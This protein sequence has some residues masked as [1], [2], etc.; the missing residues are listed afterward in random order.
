MTM[1]SPRI[2]LFAMASTLVALGLAFVGAGGVGAYFSNPARSA[3]AIL[4]IVLWLAALFSDANLSPGEREDRSDRWVLVAFGVIGLLNAFLPAYTD[5]LDVWTFGGETIRWIGVALFAAG[6][7]LRLWPVF[8]LGNRFSGLV[9]IQPGHRLVTSGIYSVIRNPSYL[10]LLVN[11]LGWALVFR[12][13]AGLMLTA[14]TLVPLVARIRSEERLLR[15]HF[16]APYEAYFSRTWRLV[17]G[18]Y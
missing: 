10:G 3:A 17:P 11:S 4:T 8:V 18:L 7:V 2:L 1:T 12:S 16:G 5:R 6:G 9:A 13:V 15:Q 14:L